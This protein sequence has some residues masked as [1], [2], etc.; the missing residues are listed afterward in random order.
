MDKQ[1]LLSTVREYARRANRDLESMVWERVYIYLDAFNKLL[2][3]AQST[4]PNSIDFLHPI[5]TVPEEYRLTMGMI[6][7]LPEQ[8]KLKEIAA[9]FELL[10]DALERLIPEPM[11]EVELPEKPDLSFLTSTDLRTII[12]RDYEEVQKTMVAGA[13][14]ATVVMCGSI[15]EALLLDALSKDEPKARGSS[16]APASPVKKWRLETLIDVAIDLGIIGPGADKLSHSIR[17]YRN[18]IHPSVEVRSRLK[19]EN[20][21]A[22]IAIEV[23]RMIIRDLSASV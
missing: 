23:L 8:Q 6:G 7:T 19:A 9:S 18:L 4:F 15:M 20:E 16:K 14:K 2:E 12:E 13:H 11:A 21:E 1:Q 10:K 3:K 22:R 17:Q 5:D